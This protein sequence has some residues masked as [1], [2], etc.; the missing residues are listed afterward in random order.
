VDQTPNVG[1]AE[2]ALSI[3]AGGALAGYGVARAPGAVLLTA[4]GGLLAARGW[5]G[6][7][8]I[9]RA[10][11]IDRA[12]G[13]SRRGQLG[14]KVD[15]SVRVQE[16]P[17]ALFRFWRDFTNLPRVITNLERVAVV[18]PTRSHWILATPA[19][20]TIEWDSEIIN[21]IPGELIAWRSTPTSSIQHAGS[22][23]FR[24]LPDGATRVEVSLQYAP[25]AGRV[26][27]ALADLL[28]A[29]PEHQLEEGLEQFRVS[30]ERGRV[31]GR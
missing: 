2:R 14:I 19:G 26:G 6:V 23:R 21:E 16:T 15:R 4:L 13:T 9:Y 31:A 11:G 27:R 1:P 7:C 22:V 24:P 29:D 30:M 18:G 8:E 10:L 17:E 3:I 28:G 20:T 25:P 5:R 12:T